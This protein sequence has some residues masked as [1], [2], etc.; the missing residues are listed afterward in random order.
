MTQV[1]ALLCVHLFTCLLVSVLE[2]YW[3][4]EEGVCCLHLSS[5]AVCIVSEV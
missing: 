5:L 3:C 1:G 4:G 2:C